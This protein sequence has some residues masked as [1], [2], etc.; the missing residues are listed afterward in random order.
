MKLPN[1]LECCLSRTGHSVF[2]TVLMC[3]K[4]NVFEGED[5]ALDV[6]LVCLIRA[7]SPASGLIG[8]C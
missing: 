8:R 3:K 2:R 4:P 1:G 5:M 6:H 7:I